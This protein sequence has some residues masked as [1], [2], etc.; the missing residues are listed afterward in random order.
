MAKDDTFVRGRVMPQLRS[1]GLK[2]VSIE[3]EQRRDAR[4]LKEIQLYEI[5]LTSMPANPLAEVE[6]FSKGFDP[7]QLND[8]EAFVRG[9]VDEL[10]KL[11]R[12]VKGG[13]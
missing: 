11:N 8:S 6:S 5:S 2:G 13:W 1:R 3:K 4:L 9:L 7:S 10:M 12:H